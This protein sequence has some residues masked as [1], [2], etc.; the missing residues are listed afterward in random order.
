MMPQPQRRPQP[1]QQP[2][3]APPQQPQQENR[4]T[5]SSG[6]TGRQ[7][8]AWGA[9]AQPQAAPAQPAPTA[10]TP[11]AGGM[12]M[13]TGMPPQT[14]HPQSNAMGPMGSPASP[15]PSRNYYGEQGGGALQQQLQRPPDSWS[16]PA[17]SNARMGAQI[18]QAGQQ[19]QSALGR[20]QDQS[21]QAQPWGPSIMSSLP[22]MP[23]QQTY[24]QMQDAPA[25]AWGPSTSDALSQIGK[26]VQ[27]EQ[28]GAPQMDAGGS[29]MGP[30][31][32]AAKV[33][34]SPQPIQAGQSSI[35]PGMHRQRQQQRR[36]QQRSYYGE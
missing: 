7:G 18:D 26:G 10:A 33:P 15:Q 24:Q 17:Q 11:S 22:G 27:P 9:P 5:D 21:A 6:S 13:A 2:D 12:S 8:P 20:Q 19:M 16:T 28:P 35:S 34:E 1:G 29:Y 25:K 23:Q 14:P 3:A 32:D 36:M 4:S 31:Q 30:L